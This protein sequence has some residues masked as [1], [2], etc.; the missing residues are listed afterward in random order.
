MGTATHRGF[1]APRAGGARERARASPIGTASRAGATFGFPNEIVRVYFDSCCVNRPF[2]AQVQPRVRL[3]TEAILSIIAMPDV[4]WISSDLVLHEVKRTPDVGR[5]RKTSVW[6][7]SAHHT[8]QIL[9]SDERHAERLEALGFGANDALHAAL[10]S[11]EADVVL[12]TDDG[13]IR[14]AARYP[15]EVGISV[16]NPVDWIRSLP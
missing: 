13:F 1:R 16:L 4:I 15:V 3:E 5:R 14:R 8:V 11:R 7:Q 6:L 12:T 10:G 2:D 9:P